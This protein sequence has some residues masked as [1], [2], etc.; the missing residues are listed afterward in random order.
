M[1]KEELKDRT[2]KF[3]IRIIKLSRSLPNTD[4][5][6]IIRRQIIRS[7]TSVGSNYRAVCRARSTAEFISKLGIVIE[8]ADETAFWLEII[9]EAG[10]FKKELVEPLLNETNEL[11]AIFVS[12]IKTKKNNHNKLNHKSK[13]INPKLNK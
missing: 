10:I 13:I 11:A 1:T 2:K 8:E 3:A 7:G 5:G 9:I 6:R 4:E 12:T